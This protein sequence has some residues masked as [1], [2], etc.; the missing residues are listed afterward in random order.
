MTVE[1]YEDGGNLTVKALPWAYQ[2]WGDYVDVYLSADCVYVPS[3]TFKGRSDLPFYIT[4][5]VGETHKLSIVNGFVGG[6]DYYEDEGLG[7]GYEFLPAVISIKNGVA[8]GSV[9]GEA[10]YSCF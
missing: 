3:L 8:Y 1:I 4:G 7:A 5:Q 10:F 2:Y 9:F 6:T